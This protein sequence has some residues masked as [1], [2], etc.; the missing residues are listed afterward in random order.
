[1]AV[2]RADLVGKPAVARAWP[3]FA[4]APW[5]L[6]DGSYGKDEELT[7][8]GADFINEAY[9][10]AVSCVSCQSW[11]TGVNFVITVTD[12]LSL[13]GGANLE[14]VLTK[15]AMAYYHMKIPPSSGAAKADLMS[16][17]GDA[18]LYAGFEPFRPSGAASACDSPCLVAS[19]TT[20]PQ[21]TVVLRKVDQTAWGDDMFIVVSMRTQQYTPRQL[22]LTPAPDVAG[23]SVRL[24]KPVHR[25]RYFRQQT[26]TG[27]ANQPLYFPKPLHQRLRCAISAESKWNR[28][29]R[30]RSRAVMQLGYFCQC[31]FASWCPAVC[32]CRQHL[33]PHAAL[34]VFRICVW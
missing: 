31:G 5:V 22:T 15:G 12:V 30:G 9:Q 28:S 10:L 8:V 26:G 4:D 2:A 1:M 24:S 7:L 16:L 34:R 6:A 20:S 33:H 14:M 13:E 27:V 23:Q 3:A 11:Q 32:R 19:Y 25:W 17:E 21:D 29:G 18:D